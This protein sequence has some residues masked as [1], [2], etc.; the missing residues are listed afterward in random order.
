MST[1][2]QFFGRVS[3]WAKKA[4]ERR[5]AVLKQAVQ[6]MTN[7]MQ[8]SRFKG[9]RMPVDQGFLRNSAVA[10]GHEFTPGF[11]PGSSDPNVEGGQGLVTAIIQWDPLTEEFEF[12]WVAN[13]AV[14]MDAKYGFYSL[15][16]QRWP[17]WVK[18]ANKKVKQEYTG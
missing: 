14:Y 13:Y 2:D 17:Q 6:D 5:D 10:N 12:H 9:G 15:G 11:T 8:Q 7:D 4:K 16:V 3:N 18:D 1:P